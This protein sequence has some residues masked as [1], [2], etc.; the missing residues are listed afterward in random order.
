MMETPLT[1]NIRPDREPLDI[2]EYRAG[3]RLPGR[4]QGAARHDAPAGPGRGR[5][6]RS[7]AAAAGPAFPPGLKWSFVPMGADAPRPKY[8]VVNADEMEPGTFK[9]RLLLEGDPHQLIEG[10]DRRRLCHRGRVAYIFLRWDYKLAASGC[11]TR[12]RRGLCGGLSGQEH[13][14]LGL[15]PGVA[16]AHQRRPLHVRRRDRA[17]ECPGGQTRHA[18]GQA[19]LSADVRP[20]GKPTSS[21]TWRRSATCRTSSTA[22]P[23][24]SR[25]SAARRRRHE[26]LRRQRARE[27]A[28]PLGTAD[29]NHRS[30]KSS[31]NTRAAC[32]T[33][34]GSA[35]LMPGGARP[36]SSSRSTSICR[37]I[38][39]ACR[40]PAAAWAPAR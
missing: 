28:G 33:A 24:G 8:L 22:A 34:T 19:A 35:A 1:Q 3:R 11:T 30:A 16:P 20:L 7:S 25:V 39:T 4:A 21:T 40:K 13:P 17:V 37:W 38:S 18:A 10:D 9:D 23:T 6:I 29:G 5:A 14:R 36:T 15:Q 12:D 32:E 31:K 27:T 26:A 2:A